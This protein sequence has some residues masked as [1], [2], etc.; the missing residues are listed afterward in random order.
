[1]KLVLYYQT[2]GPASCLACFL[3]PAS[4]FPESQVKVFLRIRYLGIFTCQCQGFD[5]GGP[6]SC[7]ECA[8]T[9][10]YKLCEANPCLNYAH[11]GIMDLQAPN[12]VGRSMSTKRL[13]CRVSLSTDMNGTA[14]K[15]AELQ[16]CSKICLQGRNWWMRECMQF[17]WRLRRHLEDL[18]RWS[19]YWA[20]WGCLPSTSAGH[21]PV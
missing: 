8:L 19:R 6:S 20:S 15:V 1:M 16:A 3:L 9:L 18:E 7:T 2:T 21:L 14:M 5:T 12:G 13:T 4:S 11:A 10:S 17:T